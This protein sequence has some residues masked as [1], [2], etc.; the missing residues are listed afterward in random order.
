M[1][2]YSLRWVLHNNTGGG[3]DPQPPSIIQPPAPPSVNQTAGESFASQLQYNPQLTAQ[4]VQL[5]GQY[6]PQLAQQQYDLSSQ[7]GPLYKSMLMQLN[8]ALGSYE[9]QVNQ[10]LASPGG[11][12]PQQQQSIDAIRNREQDRGLRGI[13]EGANLGGTLYGGRRQQMESDYLTQQ[14]QAY[15]AQDIGFQQQQ[16]AANQ[17][18]LVTLLQLTNPNVQQPQ[19]PQYGQSVVPGGDNLYN[20][21]LGYQS[22][23]GV[24]PGNSGKPNPLTMFYDPRTYG[25]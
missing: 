15:T 12:S 22:N 8:P 13:R 4:Q 2:R 21:L 14:G 24:Q 10:R 5:Q 11:Y 20:S 23:F 7:Y 17:Q 9:Q 18:A 25:F 1:R 16:Q 3:G 19:V 6:G